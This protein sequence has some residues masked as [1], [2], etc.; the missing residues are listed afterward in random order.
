VDHQ[1][2]SESRG[3]TDRQEVLTI[4]VDGGFPRCRQSQLQL[5]IHHIHVQSQSHP[6]NLHNGLS[7]KDSNYAP[8]LIRC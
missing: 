3:C 8:T 1:A 2:E 4:E 5:Q 6:S 7:R